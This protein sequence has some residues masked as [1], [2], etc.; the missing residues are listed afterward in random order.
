MQSNQQH[1]SNMNNFLINGLL[2]L[3]LNSVFQHPNI[4]FKTTET[5]SNL[6]TENQ[7]IISTSPHEQTTIVTKLSHLQEQPCNQQTFFRHLRTGN[8]WNKQLHRPNFLLKPF[9]QTPEQRCFVTTRFRIDV[10]VQNYLYHRRQSDIPNS[11]LQFYHPMLKRTE[12]KIAGW[13]NYPPR[14]ISNLHNADAITFM[15]HVISSFFERH[16]S[17][18]FQLFSAPLLHPKFI[19]NQYC[20]VKL[21]MLPRI[22]HVQ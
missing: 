8:H 1:F 13:E 10:T 11:V 2:T 20:H 4:S 15:Y 7:T 16:K 18:K 14:I 3:N 17:L 9:F 22:D 6:A 5:L 19:Q 12:Y 21:N